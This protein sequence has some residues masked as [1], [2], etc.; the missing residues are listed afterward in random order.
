MKLK[1]ARLSAEAIELLNSSEHK[2]VIRVWDRP[3]EEVRYIAQ[4][5]SE[6][7]GA[8]GACVSKSEKR[9]IFFKHPEVKVDLK[10]LF[11][12]FLEKTNGRG[13]GPP[14]LM[15]AGNLQLSNDTLALLESVFSTVSS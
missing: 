10:P 4:R 15:E 6:Q 14:H 11:T 8:M 5:L 2:V 3:F 12:Q 1:E 7:A 13:G 9:C